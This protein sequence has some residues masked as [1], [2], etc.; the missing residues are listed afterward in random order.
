[1]IE[2]PEISDEELDQLFLR[3]GQEIVA[4]LH[5]DLEEKLRE[6]KSRAG[7]AEGRAAEPLT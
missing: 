4:L 3:A 7:M 5:I 1:M 6:V 2:Q